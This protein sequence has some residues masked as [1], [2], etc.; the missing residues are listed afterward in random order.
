M[1]P[2]NFAYIHVYNMCTIYQKSTFW[3][4]IDPTQPNLWPTHPTLIFVSI[5]AS[6][7]IFIFILKIKLWSGPKGEGASPNDPINTP[8]CMY[9]L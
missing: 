4:P 9:M 8:Q 2:G 7:R 6:T 5:T 3:V 1:E